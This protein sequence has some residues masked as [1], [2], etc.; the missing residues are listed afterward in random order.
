[1]QKSPLTTVKGDFKLQFVRRM[2][3]NEICLR[4]MKWLRH[5]MFLR[6]MKCA[7][8]HM[9]EG[10]F[11]FMC[12]AHFMMRSIISCFACETFHYFPPRQIKI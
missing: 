11:H 8:A 9:Y 1:M 4:Q 6:N 2:R 5:E 10:K 7:E 12:V 3:R